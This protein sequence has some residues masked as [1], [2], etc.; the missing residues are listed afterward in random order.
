[1]NEATLN[2]NSTQCIK[3][4]SGFTQKVV[5]NICNGTETVVPYGALDITIGFVLIG[6]F[7]AILLLLLIMIKSVIRGY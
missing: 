1:M 6:V 4:V 3:E 2:L 5:M 7:L